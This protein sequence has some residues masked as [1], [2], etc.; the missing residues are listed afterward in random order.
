MGTVRSQIFLTVTATL[1]Y[2]P[3]YSVSGA[4]FPLL[5]V[6]EFK[7]GKVISVDAEPNSDLILPDNGNDTERYLVL[8]C[9]APYPVQWIY[10]GDGVSETSSLSVNSAFICKPFTIQF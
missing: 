9:K 5:K 6:Y 4:E 10:N 3:A 1:L 8:Q 2:G 7:E